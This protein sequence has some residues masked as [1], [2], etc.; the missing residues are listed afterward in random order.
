M[1]IHVRTKIQRPDKEIVEAFKGYA[2]ATIHEAS[3]RKGYI[4]ARIK[5][6]ASGIKVCGPA[7]TVQC[8]AGDNMM[9]H[10]ALELAQPGDV[11][12]ATVGGAEEYGY[13]G[14][15]MSVSAVARKLGG[16]CIEGCIRDKEDIAELGFPVF[17][18]G[19]CIRGTGKGTLGLIN[20]ITV[21]GGQSIQPGDLIVG[22]DDGLVLVRRED[23]AEVLQ[24][25]MSRVN[26]EV[27]KAKALSTGISSVEY[28]N[29]GPK[30]VEAGLV[31]E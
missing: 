10:K 30:F 28:N 21:F 9:L 19:L 13:W 12:V 5:P 16:L 26:A 11:I 25:T 18:T 20:Y 27:I 22:D 29:L 2:S 15:L 4:S 23:C 6:I 24:K 7:F 31:E 3:G 17:S 8:P 14:D 1:M